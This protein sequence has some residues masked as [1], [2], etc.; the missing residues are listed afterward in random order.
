MIAVEGTN[1]F[2]LLDGVGMAAAALVVV[3]LFIRH[4]KGERDKIGE[5]MQMAASSFETRMERSEKVF[6]I[7]L[8]RVCAAHEK[9]MET[10]A[11]RLEHVAESTIRL[12]AQVAEVLKTIKSET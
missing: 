5:S 3:Y 6:A 9:S 10:L 2:D 11:N 12:E 1:V 4:L 7:S 8:E